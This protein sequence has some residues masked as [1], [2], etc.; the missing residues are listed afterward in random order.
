MNRLIWLFLIVTRL[1]DRLR[2]PNCKAVGTYKLHAPGPRWRWLCKYCGFYR[3]E[4]GEKW[5]VPSPTFGCWIFVDQESGYK[6]ETTQRAVDR[7]A[8]EDLKVASNEGKLFKPEYTVWPWR[9]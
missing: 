7:Q 6:G 4:R 2:C 1:R 5:C 9:G 3:D 8:L